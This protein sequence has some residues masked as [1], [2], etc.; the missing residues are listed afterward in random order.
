MAIQIIEDRNDHLCNL[1]AEKDVLLAGINNTDL[2]E[3]IQ[4][5]HFYD[6]R[7]RAIHDAIRTL[8]HDGKTADMVALV[9]YCLRHPVAG[10]TPQY[11]LSLNTTSYATADC[12]FGQNLTLLADLYKRRRAR[13]MALRLMASLNDG[14]ADIDAVL[15]D[16]DREKSAI[17]QIGEDRYLRA[18]AIPSPQQIRLALAQEPTGIA[19]HYALTRRGPLHEQQPLVLPTGAL[20]MVCGLTSHGKS[21]FL[22]NLALDTATDRATTGT[23]LYYTFEE[24]RKAVYRELLNIYANMRLSANN[25][26]TIASYYHGRCFFDRDVS[27]EAFEGREREFMGLLQQ[28]RLHIVEEDYDAQELCLSIRRIARRQRVSAVF[29]DYAQLIYKAGNTLPRN[30][31]LKAIMNDLLRVARDVEVPV[32]LAAQLNRLVVSPTTMT[33]Q[34]IADSADMERIAALVLML[35]NSSYKTADS[36]ATRAMAELGITLGE[37]GKLYVECTKYRGAE[38]GNTAVLDFDGNTGRI[39]PNYSPDNDD[40]DA[41]FDGNDPL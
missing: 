1:Q 34:N 36:Q 23:V 21:R 26:R 15:T 40:P 7:H 24:D 17:E 8:R 11:V 38:R 32:V 27:V 30:E 31:E 18:I 19:T 25:L 33:N 35:W 22:Q 28:G 6:V 16:V 39:T 37:E 2:F 4:P 14:A 10:L 41:P 3:Q 12:T 20:T 13:D 5:E 9:D 29:V